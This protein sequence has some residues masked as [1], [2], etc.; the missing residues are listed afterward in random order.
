MKCNEKYLI[1][2]NVLPENGLPGIASIV[3]RPEFGCSRDDFVPGPTK[4]EYR[5][6]PVP[7]SFATVYALCQ[8]PCGLPLARA[9]RQNDA[10][11]RILVRVP[12]VLLLVAP[13]V[14]RLGPRESQRL[15]NPLRAHRQ[16]AGLLRAEHLAPPVFAIL[17]NFSRNISDAK[18]M[19]F[20]A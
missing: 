5:S 3:G 1:L 19:T 7:D 15:E 6:D 13:Q 10:L 14:G 16:R 12:S 11:R 17:G 18:R 4:F 2:W 8:P 9:V 20:G